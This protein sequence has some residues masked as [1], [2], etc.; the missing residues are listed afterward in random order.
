MSM[1]S[2]SLLFQILVGAG[3]IP[4]P[5]GVRVES[6][7]PRIELF[8]KLSQKE[9]NFAFH[10]F[11]A[12]REGRSLMYFESHRNALVI[13]DTL[14]RSLS[15]NNLADTKALLG[16]EAFAEYLIYAAKFLDNYGPYDSRS[17]IKHVLTKVNP[18]S[19]RELLRLHGARQLNPSGVEEIVGLLTNPEVE[20][21]RKP[22]ADADRLEDSGGNFYEKGITKEEVLAVLDKKLSIGLNCRVERGPNGLV[23]N[24]HTL[25]SSGVV[26]EKLKVLYTHLLKAK[27][28]ASSDHQRKQIDYFLKYLETGDERDFRDFN[29]QWL[30]DGTQS[31]IDLMI[32]W[33][34]TYDD[35]LNRIGSWENYLLVVDRDVTLKSA[36]LAKSAQLFENQ[37][38]YEYEVDGQTKAYRKV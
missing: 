34:E 30:K 24:K 16:P 12:A 19:V 25:N 33:V 27:A 15:K 7:K 29:I 2:I 17:Q 5:D 32:G 18:D 8:N 38:P 21:R 10:L 11:Q 9:K 26:G 22:V 14:T 6:S 1:L 4:L 37:M 3:P 13:R 20:L 23:C 36:A 31:T 35:W 28:Y